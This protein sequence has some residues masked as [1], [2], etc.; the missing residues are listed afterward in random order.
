[1]KGA[2][3]LDTTGHHEERDSHVFDKHKVANSGSEIIRIASPLVD[4][5]G[6]NISKPSVQATRESMQD[7]QDVAGMRLQCLIVSSQQV[8][9]IRATV[10]RG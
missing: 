1:M 4:T 6:P 2:A 7:F 9:I 8:P 10:R 3:T 5:L